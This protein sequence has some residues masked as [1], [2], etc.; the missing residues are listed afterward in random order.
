MKG[1]AKKVNHKELAL[2]LEIGYSTFGV[3]K[4]LTPDDVRRL[5]SRAERRI[6]SWAK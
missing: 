4:S 6:P 3:E 2:L 5:L 1:T